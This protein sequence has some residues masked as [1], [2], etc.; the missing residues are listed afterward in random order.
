MTPPTLILDILEDRNY[1]E[2]K[3]L[4][5]KIEEE[6]TESGLAGVTRVRYGWA[7]E[8]EEPTN[9]G[10]AAHNLPNGQAGEVFS[11]DLTLVGSGL[12]GNYYLWID[13]SEVTDY[14]GN[15]AKQISHRGSGGI[16]VFGPYMFDNTAPVCGTNNGKTN[17]TK[18]SYTINQYCLDNAG[19]EDQS[20]CAQGLYIIPYL[21]SHIVKS[22]SVTIYDKLGHSTVCNYN[23]YLDNTSPTCDGVGG[24][25]N[26][27]K[28]TYT[29]SQGCIEDANSQSGCSQ[30]IFTQYYGANTTVKN[31]NITISDNV[32]NTRICPTNVY[33]D[34][35]NPVCGVSSGSSTT[36]TNQT[37]TVYVA[38]SDNDSGCT[39]GVF[40]KAHSSSILTDSITITD[41]AG[42]SVVCGPYNYYVDTDRPNCNVTSVT[43]QCTSGGVTANIACSDSGSV[44]SGLATCG[45][46][47]NPSP[48]TAFA[49][50]LTS[51]YTFTVSDKA[52][53]T[54][55]CSVHV[56]SVT[57]YHR[58]TC[59]LGSR[60]EAAGCEAAA[61]CSNY[62]CGTCGGECASY[63]YYCC[64]HGSYT[65]SNA[66]TCNVYGS[67]V[68]NS[69]DGW[70]VSCSRNACTSY[71]PTYACTCT[72]LSCCG[73]G[74]YYRSIETCGC[75]TW[76]SWG[77]WSED[78][79]TCAGYSTNNC[80]IG[81]RIL[82]YSGA[83]CNIDGSY[84]GTIGFFEADR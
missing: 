59:S 60:C 56:R 82:Y 38:C 29:V 26:W 16:A 68:S 10:I 35:T 3:V 70:S 74:T 18:G 62:C 41:V 77:A 43:E 54:S 42:N 7:L 34:N 69:G 58:R 11:T 83:G 13:Y 66:G 63:N 32:G 12:T 45:D 4:N 47:S 22:D 49:R 52:G 76:N 24:K 8:G 23:V 44:M 73:C 31:D 25:T 28:G 48:Y 80:D 33:L 81:T 65:G 2:D 37:R 21:V 9:W 71:Y 46:N 19:T 1:T 30:S 79:L 67:D 36:W 61:T 72:S 20:G 84:S 17:W 14:A 15:Y 57:H 50:K 39:Q 64:L 40:S 55:V 6:V 78:A 75:D 53:N 51:N 5:L 27:T